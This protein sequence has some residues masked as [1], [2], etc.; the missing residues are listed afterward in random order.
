MA[1][2]SSPICWPCCRAASAAWPANASA[3]HDSFVCEPDEHFYGFGEKFTEFDKR[4]QRI[5]MWNCDAYGVHNERAY[6]NVP[7]FV[8]SRGYG[9]FVDSVRPVNFDMGQ[10]NHAA[11][12]LIVPDSA[13]DY[14]VIAGPTP[15]TV[16]ERYAGLVSRPMTPPKW[17]FG[18]W[19]SSGFKDD[20]AAAGP[21]ARAGAARPRRAMRRAASRLLLAEVRTLVGEPV[22]SG[23]VP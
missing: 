2:P 9:V 23:D 20:S 16:I 3:F 11:F 14:Y 21:G 4:G 7:F 19:M 10:S 18:L 12:S 13:L 6:K 15:K 1:P 22:G 5:E 8:S 17:A